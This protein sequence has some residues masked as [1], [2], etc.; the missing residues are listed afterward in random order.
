MIVLDEPVS[1]LDVV[2]RGEILGLLHD[3][4]DRLDVSYL[5]ISHDLTAVRSVSK[6][7]AVM[8]LGRIVEVEETEALFARPLH[9]YTRSLLGAVLYP[10]PSAKGASY[11]LSGEIPSPINLPIGCP[12]FSRCPAKEMEC[13]AW[14][15]QLLDVSVDLTTRP[16]ACR[17]TEEMLRAGTV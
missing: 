2:G 8:Y 4:Q 17:R 3:L 16:V 13:S 11:E 15:P 5:F 9:P 10:D 7:I 1:N 12:L 6:R 14:E